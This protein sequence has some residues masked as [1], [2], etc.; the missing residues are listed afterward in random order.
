[1]QMKVIWIGTRIVCLQN[2]D[3]SMEVSISLEDGSWN[4]KEPPKMG[5]WVN[6][7]WGMLSNQ[8]ILER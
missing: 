2:V 1:M 3:G 4:K 6:V 7:V 5:Q 8:W